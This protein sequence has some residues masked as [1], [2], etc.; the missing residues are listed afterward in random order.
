MG[1]AVPS[2]LDFSMASDAISNL[3]EVRFDVS[4]PRSLVA[5]RL[6]L[7]ISHL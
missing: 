4:L 2:P 7:Q 5:F 1:K 3:K 6:F